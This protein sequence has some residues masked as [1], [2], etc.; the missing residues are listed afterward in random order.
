MQRTL[1]IYLWPCS[2]W[3]GSAENKR[4]NL[5]WSHENN[6][7]VSQV[8]T[9][10]LHVCK[11]VENYDVH[12]KLLFFFQQ[13]ARSLTGC[14]AM[15]DQLQPVIT[16]NLQNNV[17]WS[18]VCLF[19]HTKCLYVG[20]NSRSKQSYQ[21]WCGL[22]HKS[23]NHLQSTSAHSRYSVFMVVFTPPSPLPIFLATSLL[24]ILILFSYCKIFIYVVFELYLF[25]VSFVFYMLMNVCVVNNVYITFEYY[26]LYCIMPHKESGN[27]QVAFWKT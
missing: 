8:M 27:L 6:S 9:T 18:C 26:F 17:I 10:R 11:N 15:W 7:E 21:K 25:Y 14:G 12:K 23:M 22:W 2:C 5:W 3:A 13:E 20:P 16:V 4:E 1:V 24:E 19:T